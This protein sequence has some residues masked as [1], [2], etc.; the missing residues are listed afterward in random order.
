MGPGSPG[1]VQ[2]QNNTKKPV[3][4]GLRGI[5]G[6]RFPLILSAQASGTVFTS[7]FSQ[8]SD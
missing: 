3:G 8:V 4:G 7:L 5:D 1:R 2:G 6:Q